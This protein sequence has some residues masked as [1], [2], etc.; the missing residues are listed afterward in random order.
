MTSSL[1]IMKSQG[2][3]EEKERG[4]GEAGG[5]LQ[6]KGGVEAPAGLGERGRV[7]RATFLNPEPR[8]RRMLRRRMR[9]H[10]KCTCQADLL[11]TKV[12]VAMEAPL[13]IPSQ[14]CGVFILESKDH[15][16]ELWRVGLRMH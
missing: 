7:R 15:S 3:R 5:G 11:Q 13:V 12:S 8:D 14:G 10:G 4:P 1:K 16:P 9:L 6:G 2:M